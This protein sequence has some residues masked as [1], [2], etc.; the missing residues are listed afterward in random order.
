MTV[1][2]LR[3]IGSCGVARPR[4]EV[5]P[6]LPAA[7]APPSTGAPHR[8]YRRTGPRSKAAWSAA[9]LAQII[10]QEMFA[11]APAP[12]ATRLAAYRPSAPPAF[13]GLNYRTRA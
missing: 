3:S 4:G 6:A 7:A 13:E 10:A 5:H 11:P 12:R 1:T 8:R 2:A 9:F